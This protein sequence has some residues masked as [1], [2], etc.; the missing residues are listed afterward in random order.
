MTRTDEKLEAQAK[1]LKMLEIQVGQIAE[2]INNQR[3]QGQ[4]PSNTIVNPK[5]H[6]KAI[7]LRSGTTYEE[8]K[9][10]D[11]EDRSGVVVE[12]GDGNPSK[13]KG[14]RGKKKEVYVAPPPYCPPI[15]FPQRHQKKNVENEFSKFLEIFRKVHINIPLVEALKQMPSYAKFLKEV[16]SN[17]R[18]MGENETVN[19]TEE[20]SA[21]LQRKIPTKIK[22]PRSFTIPCDIGNDRFGKALCD[23]GASINLMPLSI[24]NKLEIGTIK[25]TTIA[26]QK[27]DRSVSYPKG[28]VEDVLVKVNNFIF[29]VDFV[30]LDMVE[31]KDVPLILGRP[32]LATGRALIDVAKGE[33]TLRVNDE[34]F[35]FSIH[36]AL[37]YKEEE[38]EMRVDECK[39]M[40]VIESCINM[41]EYHTYNNPMDTCL[42]NPLFSFVDNNEFNASN[43]FVETN[44][45]NFVQE[46]SQGEAYF[47]DLR[48]G[49]PKDEGV[50]KKTP[51]LELKP[52]PEHLK[53]AFLG[54]DEAYP[55]I[56]SS[57]LSPHEL[58]QLLNVLRKYR[59]A[60]GWSISDLKGIS[61]SICMHRILMEDD[62]KPR[63]QGQ[64]RE[65]VSP[66]QVVAKKG[67]ITVIKD[68]HDELIAT[69]CKETNLVLN[70]EKC[71]FMVRDGIV[72]GHKVSKAGLEVD[73]AKIVAIEKLPPPS[74]EKAVRSFLG[75]A[76]FYRR[77]I[78]DFSKITKPLC[79]L[80]EKDTKFNF[81]KDCLVAFEKLKKA[82]VSAPILITP[83]WSQPFELMCDASDIAVGAVLGQKKDKL[84]RVIYYASRTLDM[85][86]SNYTVMEKELL[87]VVYAFDKFRSYLIGTKSI[88]HTDHAAIRYLFEKKD[89]K[90]RLIRWILLLQEFNIEIRDRRGCENVVA[91]HLS[92]LENP[93]EGENANVPI[94]ENFPDEQILQVK[95]HTPWYADY[96][97]Y[98]ASG[99]HPPPKLN[100]YQRKKFFHD[101]KF[102]LWDEPFLYR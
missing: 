27:A 48:N 49:E 69:R 92:R 42:L 24:F 77:F 84:F 53:Y 60:I 73:R 100:R 35:T 15:P 64:R 62:F 4:F 40:Q 88:V 44:E 39:M 38:E 8:P 41:E 81:D 25:P 5:E 67:G 26:L 2:S 9:M 28:I 19:L 80:L 6:C 83:D 54:Q 17:K 22:D 87:A 7:A 93:V 71:H 68:E 102:F 76:G 82:F 86:Q 32:F 85:A 79:H 70:W 14:D 90:P 66:T 37:K 30:V 29:P 98:L 78:Q 72:L 89:A 96:V 50:E 91:D 20:C 59:S 1:Q 56:V 75:H 94:N 11:E 74:N 101:V 99:I 57:Y 45:M 97:N 13:E 10:P 65:W 18:K 63:R 16:I 31:D 12:V 3:Q 46:I 58:D 95:A 52:L 61:P 36:K 21:V 23:L 55:V 43:L 51:S 33:L 47:L 34:S